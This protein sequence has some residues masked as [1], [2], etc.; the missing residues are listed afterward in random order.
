MD[1]FRAAWKL[2][3]QG[4]H[5][6]AFLKP[7]DRS[8][9]ANE[10]AYE[11]RR[12]L[13]PPPPPQDD[14]AAG[15]EVRKPAPGAPP[16]PPQEARGPRLTDVEANVPPQPAPRELILPDVLDPNAEQPP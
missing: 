8:Q 1:F 9:P 2:S 16:V 4:T 5:L 10:V 13:P 3:G 12:A 7:T 15:V 6:Q 14:P 11:R